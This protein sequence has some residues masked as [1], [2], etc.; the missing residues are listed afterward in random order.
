MARQ[1]RGSRERAQLFQDLRQANDDV[2]R[3]RGWQK[4]S[5]RRLV[6]SDSPGVGLPPTDAYA[7]GLVD[8]KVCASSAPFEL[9]D[10]PVVPTTDADKRFE[11]WNIEVFLGDQILFEGDVYDVRLIEDVTPS[12]A[13]GSVETESDAVV[14]KSNDAPEE[15]VAAMCVVST[16]PAGHVSFKLEYTD[17]SGEW[18]VSD[19]IAFAADCK[20]GDS[21][22]ITTGGEEAVVAFVQ[23]ITGFDGDLGDGVLRIVD[24]CPF[25][26]RVLAGRRVACL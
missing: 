8:L 1:S 18:Q 20:V 2:R 13:L 26:T 14:F 10:G 5:I 4:A 7:S 12:V 24:N 25:R 21:Q 17:D 15:S 11:F 3:I 23:D 16:K 6:Q 22:V 19:T 9:S